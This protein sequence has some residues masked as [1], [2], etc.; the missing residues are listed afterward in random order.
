MPITNNVFNNDWQ[1]PKKKSKIASIGFQTIT[2][3]HAII[4]QMETWTIV[5]TSR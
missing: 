5:I 1:Q 4:D 2:F 3:V